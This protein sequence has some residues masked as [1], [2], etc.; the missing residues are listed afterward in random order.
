MPTVPAL[1]RPNWLGRFLTDA[2]YVLLAFPY[3]LVSFVVLFCT[4]LLGAVNVVTLLGLPVLFAAMFLARMFANGE[5]ALL[6]R[7]IRVP[8]ARVNYKQPPADAGWWRRIVTPL[9]DGQNWLDLGHGLVTFGTSLASFILLASWTIGALSGVTYPIWF[10]ALPD[11]PDDQQFHQLLGLPDTAF[12][13]IAVQF[14]MGLVFLITLPPVARGAAMLRALPARG[15][16]YSVSALRDRITDLEEQTVEARAQTAAAVSAEA[17]ALR[18]LER[19]IHDGPQQ[20]LVRLAMDL[21]RAQHQLDNDPDAARAT[22]GEALAQTRE[23]LAELRALSRGI[24]PPILADRGLV[25][26]VSALAGRSTVPVEVDWPGLAGSGDPRPRLDAAVENAAYFVI[27]EALTNVAKHSHATECSV[28]LERDGA[29][30]LIEIRDNGVGGA[31]VSKG[32]GLSGLADRVRAA[33]GVLTI[34]SPDGGPTRL[35]AELPCV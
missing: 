17:T 35:L 20:R 12:A 15:M 7:V 27:A 24:A 18:R 10:W 11:S 26:A 28:T 1:P 21:G 34:D 9:T 14:S 31:H 23:T 16:L 2:V 29:Y 5:R 25:A 4:F 32:H 13:N 33:G 30:L 6:T 3:G 8:A 19:D 22:V